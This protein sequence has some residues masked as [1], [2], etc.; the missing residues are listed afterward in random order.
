MRRFAAVT[1]AGFLFAGCA[2]LQAASGPGDAAKPT[3]VVV[4]SVVT[5]V[6]NAIITN[7]DVAR[8]ERQLATDMQSQT[9]PPSP[10]EMEQARKD[11]LRDLINQQLLLQRASDLGYSAETETIHRLDQIRRSMNLPTMEDLQK[12]VEAQGEDYEDFKQQIKNGIL[13]QMV[14]E[15]DV[16]PR[17][18]IDPEEVQKYYNQHKTAFVSQA[19]VD[20]S[21]ILISTKDQPADKLLRL[22]ALADQI[23]VRAARGEDFSKLATR[24]SNGTT[25]ATGGEIGF[26]LKGSL[27]PELEKVVFN[28]PEGGI[29]PV[30]TTPN[31]YLLLRVNRL[32]HAGQETLDEARNQVQQ[33]LYEQKLQPELRD[34]LAHL[35]SQAYIKVA[36]GYVDTGASASIGVNLERFERVLPQDLPK[37]V[38][39]PNSGGAG[40]SGGPQL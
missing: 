3:P 31:G 35:R 9:P 23:Q 27:S 34:Y 15:Q 25:A 20:L 22:K 10:Q 40:I 13:Q 1:V 32:R 38:E 6:N 16:A 26:Q 12:A 29:T 39:K 30:I 36:A 19:G 7:I 33:I 2:A 28:L 21:E 14:I 24:Y 37:P 5:R 17:I 18:S 8:A 11:L 4:E